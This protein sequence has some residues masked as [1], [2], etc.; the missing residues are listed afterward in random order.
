MMGLIK[1]AE[2]QYLSPEVSV[3]LGYTD[4]TGWLQDPVLYH[5]TARASYLPGLGSAFPMYIL[6]NVP[7]EYAQ[8]K[9]IRALGLSSPVWS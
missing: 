9:S 1:G 5:A 4:T 7:P 3:H 2:H 8:Q 6:R